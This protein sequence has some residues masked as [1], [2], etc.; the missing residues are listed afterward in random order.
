M[1]KYTFLLAFGL[2]FFSCDS[3]LDQN[4]VGS[5]TD[6]D[7]WQTESDLRDAIAGVYGPWATRALGMDDLFFDNQSD[8]HWRAGDH[9]EDEEIETYNTVPSNTKIKDTY[10]YKYEVISRANGVIINAPKVKAAGAISEDSYN[11][12]LGQAYFLRAYAYYRLYLIH[13]QVP[14]I[15]EENV[16]N[17][18]YNQPKC[19]SPEVLANFILEDLN[20]AAGL[21]PMHNIT[22]SVSKGAA[23]AVMT[24]IYMHLA[25]EYTD[26]ENLNKAIASGKNVIDNYPLAADYL[27]LFRKGNESLPE[28]L[29]LMMNDMS[30]IN[31]ELLSKH[32]GPRP[33]GMYGFNEPHTDLVNEFETGDK[34]KKTTIVSDGES[35]SQAGTI[36][37]HTPGL[38]NTGHSYFKYMD[39]VTPETFNHGLN[40]P[41]LRAADTYLLVAEAKIRLNGAGA[42]DA[43]INAVRKRAGLAPVTKADIKALIHETRVELAGENFRY[44]NLLRWDKA[45]I[46]DLQTFLVKPEKM[47]PA[48][49]GRMKWVRPKNYYQPLPQIEIDNSDGILKQ[50]PDWVN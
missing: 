50:N 14:I 32:R 43:E 44:Q 33:W 36:V 9:A 48:D 20:I 4:L 45:G 34:R 2:L 37:V 35:V 42:G 21:L 13:G 1:K 46:Y 38:S 28:N 7:Y 29:F 49:L 12:I 41:F 31:Q 18:E 11:S 30:W 26:S 15:R 47:F 3:I 22:G 25:K 19:E 40:I 24:S 39:W 27:S 17:N 23:W 6:E 5:R 8:D 10:Q 16:L